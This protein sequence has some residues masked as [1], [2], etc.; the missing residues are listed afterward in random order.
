MELPN[1]CLNC[2]VSEPWGKPEDICN[3][4]C[5]MTAKMIGKCSEF[6]SPLCQETLLD[7]YKIAVEKYRLET[8]NGA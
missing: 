1:C 6:Y 8:K 4:E 2:G 7:F 5:L 3:P